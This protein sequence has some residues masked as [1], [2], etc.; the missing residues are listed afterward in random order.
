[1]S[2]H[3]NTPTLLLSLATLF[4]TTQHVYA[5]HIPEIKLTS[6]A[7]TQKIERKNPALSH[8]AWLSGFRAYQHAR[9]QGRD[10]QQLLT[11]VN[12]NKP[13]TEKRL[14]VF[15]MKNAQM[16]YHTYVAQGENTGHN[17]AKHFS[18]TPN[19]HESSIG[20]YLTGYTYY[21][22]DGYSMH[23]YGLDP[24]FNNN[25]FKRH[26]VMHPAQYVSKQ[27]A[28][29]YGFMGHTYGCFGL[30]PKIAPKIISTIKNNT[31]LVAYYP[32]KNWLNTSA[33]EQAI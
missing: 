15:D 4:T 1:M 26:I 33:F 10:S 17:V 18:N 11:I 8:A 6:K 28:K 2:V 32:N 25:V 16:L 9:Q 7:L 31:I 23:L 30:N 27:F 20:V 29:T 14:W 5:S 13:S 24:G 21:G 19:S 12:F 22:H 3:L